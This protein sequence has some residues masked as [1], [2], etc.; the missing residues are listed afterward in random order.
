MYHPN[1]ILGNI[2]SVFIWRRI[3][4]LLANFLLIIREK[5]SLKKSLLKFKK[6]G[7]TAE[8]KTNSFSSSCG[9]P[10]FDLELIKAH[11]LLLK[12]HFRFKKG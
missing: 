9:C 10:L 7:I 12:Y 5:P 3:R 1:N 2:Q 11:P 4:Y 8:S 6:Q